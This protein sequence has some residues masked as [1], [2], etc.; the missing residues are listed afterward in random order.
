MNDTEGLIVKATGGFYYV[1]A[2]GVLYECRARGVFRKQGVSPL[3]GD[4]VTVEP[5]GESKGVVAK[6]MPRKNA[7]VRPPL[8]NV[9]TFAVVASVADPAPNTLV[10][11]KLMA[12]ACHKNISPILVVT[13]CD[14]GGP[15][16]LAGIYRTAGMPVF[17]VSKADGSGLDTLRQRLSAGGITAFSGNS[18]VGKSSL[19]NRLDGRLSIATGETSRKLGRGRHTTRHVELFRLN[20]RTL[21]VDTPGFSS[22]DTAELNLELKKAL[23][24]TFRDFEIG[25]AS[26]RERV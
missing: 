15:D 6:I 12:I 26:C 17:T 8:A 21:V 24:E 7:L 10:I 4:R 14:L 25:R 22:F 5:A 1:D 16:A 2:A 18:G 9:D 13:K 3:V 20:E 11:D 19:L 23:P